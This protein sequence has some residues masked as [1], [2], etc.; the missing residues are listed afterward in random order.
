MC[1]GLRQ[2]RQF[3]FG[4]PAFMAIAIACLASFT[5]AAILALT[6]PSA[7][8]DAE[9]TRLEAENE[10]LS[11]RHQNIAFEAQRLRARILKIEK[12]SDRIVRE[13]EAD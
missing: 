8:D 13:L 1:P 3:R 9:Y 12:T 4:R 5:V 11:L 6:Y 10:A 2:I 7:I